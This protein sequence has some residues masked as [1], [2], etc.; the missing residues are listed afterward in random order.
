MS[1]ASLDPHVASQI[2]SAALNSRY[3]LLGFMDM[4]CLH[5]PAT[6]HDGLWTY[7]LPAYLSCTTC[8]AEQVFHHKW[9]VTLFPQ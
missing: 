9:G 6:C 2:P 5:G 1:T 8:S 7:D 4:L 3:S